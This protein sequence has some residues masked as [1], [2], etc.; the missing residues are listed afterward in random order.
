MEDEL[1]PMSPT[2]QYL[3]SSS[4]SLAIIGVLES[5]TPIDDSMLMPFIKDDFLP[6]NSRFSSVV[7]IT[8][9]EGTRKWKKVE[10]NLNDHVKIPIFPSGMSI[11]YYD[12]CFTE[13]LSQIGT[14]QFPQNKPFWEIH[15]IK[16]PTKNAAGNII[17][18]L[19]H[20][21]GDG[22]SFMSALLSCLKRTENPL[23]P[24]SFPSRQ[25]NSR[26]NNNINR[27]DGSFG[28]VS[29]FLTK[30]LGTDFGWNIFMSHLIEDDK[31]SI[32]SGGD[33][34]EFRSFVTSTI[35][36]SMDQ[37]Q[38]IK[39][40]LQVT[41]ND[42]ITGVI[43]FG[44]RIYMQESRNTNEKSGE[45]KCTALVLLNTREMGGYKPVKEMIKEDAKMPWG[46]RLTFLPIP[47]PKLE[48]PIEIIKKA[49]EKIKKQRKSNTV[50]VTSQLLQLI[51]EVR[52]PE[53]TGNYIHK[54]LKNASMTISNMIGP[55]EKMELA[56]HPIKGLYWTLS[57][58]PQSLTI[59]MVSYLKNLRVAITVEKNFIDL[60]KFKSCIY[61]A[62]NEIS[63]AALDSR[64]SKQQVSK[65]HTFRN[66]APSRL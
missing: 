3:K 51:G 24:L 66:E 9:N 61:H 50:N 33:G 11:E 29:K 60:D 2:A 53:A 27:G 59:T 55:V 47:L 62:F 63:R 54:L 22:Y 7:V 14:Q 13:Y 30:L 8:K 19:H 39:S 38:E 26:P 4:L 48:N 18:K 10:V 64:M 58:P 35:T 57:G 17:F 52:G 1:E 45:E 12:K 42:V 41:I 46:N 25:S 16:Y 23:L 49:R 5:E 56:S 43:F 21:L 37:I 20:S 6:L 31:S 28:S 65:N 44:T 34:V 32:R 15:I 36:F 40:R